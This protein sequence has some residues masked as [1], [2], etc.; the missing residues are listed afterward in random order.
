MRIL[1]PAFVP[2]LILQHRKLLN[3]G[4]FMV[5]TVHLLPS[6]WVFKWDQTWALDERLGD[7][8]LPRR[9]NMFRAEHFMVGIHPGNIRSGYCDTTYSTPNHPEGQKNRL[10]NPRRY[11]HIY[12]DYYKLLHSYKKLSLWLKLADLVF[13]T[14]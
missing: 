11:T 7:A 6:Q 10:T 5:L 3:K 9:G 12:K 13:P 2:T 1:T 4:T 14:L 8:S